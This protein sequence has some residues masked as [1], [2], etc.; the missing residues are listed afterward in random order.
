VC[1]GCHAP[2]MHVRFSV[3]I[4]RKRVCKMARSLFHGKMYSI[5]F[6]ND[7]QSVDGVFSMYSGFLNQEN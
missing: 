2:G 7:L 6:V 1:R 4:F 5:K 3:Y